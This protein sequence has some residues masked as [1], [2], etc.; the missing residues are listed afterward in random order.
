MLKKRAGWLAVL[1]VGGFLSCAA[2]ASYE[3]SF[4]KWAFLVL[5]LPIIGSSGGN[6]GTQAASLIIRGLAIKE[7]EQKDVWRV[8][9]KELVM[10]LLLGVILASLGFLRSYSFDGRIGNYS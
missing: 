2:I 6:S 7:M 9:S 8:L 10:G 4:S 3:E 1:F 5:F